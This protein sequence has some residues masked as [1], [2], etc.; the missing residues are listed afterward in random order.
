[1]N[2][3][4]TDVLLSPDGQQWAWVGQTVENDGLINSTLH[5]GSLSGDR[6][7]EVIGESQRALRPY[8]WDR[9]GLVVEHE[10]IGRYGYAPFDPATGPVE[11]IDPQT[12]VLHPLKNSADCY[13]LALAL[14]GTTACETLSASGI[15]LTLVRPDYS[16]WSMPLSKPGFNFA[17]NASF[18]L[19]SGPTTVLIGGSTFDPAHA[20]TSERM[21]TGTVDVDSGSIQLFGPTGIAP[22]SG[23]DW[24]W[25]N[26]GSVIGEGWLQDPA[27]DS[28]VWVY[29]SDGSARRVSAGQAFGVLH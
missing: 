23:E 21:S 1:M 16:L 17:G 3:G 7:I 11:M 18:K 15:N 19:G 2:V 22:A 26:D 27:T 20:T 29:S 28:G 24:V 13:F 6:V 12:G 9:A 8:R 14:D 25:L 10:S 5:I 4:Y